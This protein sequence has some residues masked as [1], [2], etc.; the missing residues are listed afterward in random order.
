MYQGGVSDYHIE[1][2]SGSK[3]MIF[4][5]VRAVVSSFQH[6]ISSAL[7]YLFLEFHFVSP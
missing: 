4:K 6:S 5:S 3:Y 2:E 1:L 7:I